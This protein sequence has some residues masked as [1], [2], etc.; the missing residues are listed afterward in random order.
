MFKTLGYQC[1]L[2]A[3]IKNLIA[4]VKS[5]KFSIGN[6]NNQK[7]QTVKKNKYLRHSTV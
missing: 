2:G 7:Y 1:P 5:G 4:C 3:A 6:K